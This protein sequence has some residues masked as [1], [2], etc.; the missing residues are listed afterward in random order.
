MNRT[1]TVA[2]SVAGLAGS[3]LLLSAGLTAAVGF[4][5]SVDAP[6]AWKGDPRIGLVAAPVALGLLALAALS[7]RR[8]LGWLRALP[9]ADRKTASPGNGS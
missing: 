1:Q 6:H 8:S 5:F 9:R 3:L 2:W 7:A 4:A